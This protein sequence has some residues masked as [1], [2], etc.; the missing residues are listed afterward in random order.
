VADVQGSHC[1]F[2]RG[3]PNAL[4]LGIIVHHPRSLLPTSPFPNMR[5]NG[6]PSPADLAKHGIPSDGV[7]PHDHT[8]FGPH[9]HGAPSYTDEQVAFLEQRG[10]HCDRHHNQVLDGDGDVVPPGLIG[11]LLLDAKEQGILKAA[12]GV[13]TMMTTGSCEPPTEPLAVS[14]PGEPA[15]VVQR[16]DLRQQP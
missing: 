12:M 3:W 16:L 10:Y 9:E 2:T 11:P 1:R 7:G 15:P 5:I 6:L 8:G 14:G 13:N 4:E